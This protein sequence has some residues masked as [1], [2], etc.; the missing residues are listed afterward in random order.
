MLSEIGN[1]NVIH[2]CKLIGF[3]MASVLKVQ[4]FLQEPH[5][6][7]QRIQQYKTAS[8]ENVIQLVGTCLQF[9]WIGQNIVYVQCIHCEKQLQQWS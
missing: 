3:M 2:G 1:L 5:H 4:L 7:I 8:H 9:T 6:V